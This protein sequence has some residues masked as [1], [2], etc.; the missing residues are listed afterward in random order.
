MAIMCALAWASSAR[1]DEVE[2]K[3][4]LETETPDEGW[5][6]A[7]FRLSLGY[8]YG[9]DIGLANLPDAT[10]HSIVIRIGARL[11]AEWSLLGSFRYGIA[12]SG[13]AGRGFEGLA[14]AIT[15][16]P[17]WH[18]PAG[19]ELALGVGFAGVQGATSEQPYP[20][21][22][23]EEF[24]DDHSITSPDTRHVLES[25]SGAGPGALVR[26]GWVVALD[27]IWALALHAEGYSRWSLCE[28]SYGAVEDDGE[29]IVMR[30]WW[31]HYGATFG[32]SFAWR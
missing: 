4:S 30:Q 11:D 6:S 17:T 19:F 24:E 27:D 5:Q 8:G 32:A 13:S 16:D 23:F 21:P 7:G 2:F 3:R 29:P 10:V 26:L 25:C 1:A 12:G 15:L 18:L 22:Y 14:Y 9:F 20:N 31:G 28:E